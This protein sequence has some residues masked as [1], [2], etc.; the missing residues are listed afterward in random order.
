MIGAEWRSYLSYYGKCRWKLAAAVLLSIGVSLLSLPTILIVKYV[1]D[2]VL[3]RNNF[4]GLLLCAVGLLALAVISCAAMM[5]I[6]WS[7]LQ[8][9]EAVTMRIR[10]ELIERLYKLPRQFLAENQRMELHDTIVQDTL[11]I[12]QMGNTL[13]EQV[14]PAALTMVVVTAF[15]LKLNWAL[16]LIML[17][18]VPLVFWVNRQLGKRVHDHANS[19][20]HSFKLFSQGV[21]FVLQSMDLTR[22]RSAEQFEIARQ[23]RTLDDLRSSSAILAW[24]DTLYEQIQGLAVTFVS[25]VILIVGGAAVAAHKMSLGSLLSFYVAA[26]MLSSQI[27][28]IVNKIPQ[29]ILGRNSLREICHLLSREEREPYTGTRAVDFSGALALEGVTFSYR[30]DKCVLKDA[31]LEIKPHTTVALGGPN[32]SGKTSIVL[33]LCGFYRPQKG[34]VRASRHPY[35]DLD[36]SRLRRD[37]GVVPQ[38]PLLFPATIRE[39]IAYG[40]PDATMDEIRE[41]ARLATAHAFITSLE[42]AYDTPVGEGGALLS[43][44]QRQKIAIA[45][46]LLAQP[47]LLI[48]DEPTN[49][50]DSASI[51]QLMGNL[52]SLAQR[53]S[54]VLVTHDESVLQQVEFVYRLENGRVERCEADWQERQSVICDLQSGSPAAAP[55]R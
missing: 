11:R 28:M 52:E 47:K 53:P 3:T 7:A 49:H 42:A 8:I 13:V 50:L 37:F 36:I 22:M 41:A 29:I 34:T 46:A 10:L 54:I 43:G 26:R 20:R 16:V 1:F 51:M 24:F 17:A 40:R 2:H 55:A 31:W 44:G 39:N 35:D 14:L 25:L 27:Q 32:G 45:R 4:R 18:I 5:W 21:F 15:L 9:G 23:T 33:L 38:E 48:L 19:F 12:N 6:R 30:A